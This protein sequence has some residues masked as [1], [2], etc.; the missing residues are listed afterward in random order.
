MLVCG[1]GCTCV[2]N[3]FS[4]KKGGDAP[5]D[6][7]DTNVCEKSRHQRLAHLCEI[8]WIHLLAWLES[9]GISVC[10]VDN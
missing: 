1:Y 8:A 6:D 7:L 5:A 9:D 4:L 3:L 2:T 10:F